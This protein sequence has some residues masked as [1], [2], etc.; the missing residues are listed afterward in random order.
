MKKGDKVREI[1]DT[2]TGTIVY[3]A[4]GYADVKYRNVIRDIK[5][6]YSQPHTRD[7]TES[8]QWSFYL[9][10]FVSDMKFVLFDL[11]LHQLNQTFFFWRWDIYT[12]LGTRK[13][14]KP[15]NS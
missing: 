12:T 7:Y 15:L 5:T 14:P 4:N 11:Y 8:C 1:G 13:I 2:L 9:E 10:L 6:K 3:I